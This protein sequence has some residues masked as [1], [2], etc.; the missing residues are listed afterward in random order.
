[1]TDHELEQRLRTWY[2]AEIGANETAPLALRADLAA[3]VAPGPSMT[4]PARRPTRRDAPGGRGH[5][6]RPAHRRRH[7]RRHRVASGTRRRPADEGCNRHRVAWPSPRR[8]HPCRQTPRSRSGQDA[9][10][11]LDQIFLGPTRRLGDDGL[12]HSRPRTWVRPGPRSGRLA[13]HDGRDQLVDADTM[14]SPPTACR[15]GSRDA[16]RRRFVGPVDHR[17]PVER[18]QPDAFVPGRSRGSSTFGDKQG[19]GASASSRPRTAASTWSRSGAG[20]VPAIEASMGKIE[21]PFRG[22][23][24]LY[25]GK[26]DNKPFNNDY[27]L[28]DG[29]GRTWQT[30]TFPIGEPTRKETRSSSIGS[31]LAEGGRIVMAISAG[32]ER[33]RSGR[34]TTTGGHGASSKALPSE[35]AGVPLGRTSCPR[36]SGSFTRTMDPRSGPPWTAARPG[37]TTA[38]GDRPSIRLDKVSFASPDRG[39]AVERCRT[40][41]RPTRYCDGTSG[42]TALFATTDGGRTWTRI[43]QPTVAPSPTPA[44]V[45]SSDGSRGRAPGRCSAARP[46][47]VVPGCRPSALRD[48]RVLVVARPGAPGS[49]RAVR[50]V[51]GLWS[52]AM[53]LIHYTVLFRTA[54]LLRDGRVLIF[55]RRLIRG[56]QKTANMFTQKLA[57]G[58]TPARSRRGSHTARWSCFLTAVCSSWVAGDPP[59]RDPLGRAL[60]PAHRRA[61]RRP[62]LATASAAASARPCWR[63]ARSSSRRVGSTSRHPLPLRSSYDP[64]T[65]TWAATGNMT[66]PR[67]DIRPPSLTDGR[68]LVAAGPGAFAG[69]GLPSAEIYDPSTGTWTATGSMGEVSWGLHG[70]IAV[71]RTRACRRRIRGASLWQPSS[72]RASSTTRIPAHGPPRPEWPYN[73]PATWPRFSATAPSS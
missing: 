37:R 63:M 31:R 38:N 59:D 40:P 18:G 46:A 9:F 7:R 5:P 55:G 58:T 24:V 21:G 29:R 1:M 10:S 42:D 36:P 2:Q 8:S 28:V 53:P 64:S 67:A 20:Q 16:R 4:R 3:I 34:A 13:G 47:A 32:D 44:T 51:S 61:G 30:R 39:W 60:R 65:D 49:A 41:G 69:K 54:A 56:R 73:A 50:P 14:S 57:D 43:G 6:C 52:S 19:G 45:A 48:G 35:I 15:C 70:H 12:R 68:V 72:E 17:R 33:R 66:A 11:G 62:Q 27:R 22:R 25:S 23:A 26:Y 71:G